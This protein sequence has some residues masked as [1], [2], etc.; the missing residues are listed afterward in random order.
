[1]LFC[2]HISDGIKVGG[3]LNT[4][5][6]VEAWIVERPELYPPQPPS[7]VDGISSTNVEDPRSSESV[8]SRRAKTRSLEP[9]RKGRADFSDLLQKAQ[10]ENQQLILDDDDKN[11]VRPARPESE[12]N[13]PTAI[14]H[15]NDNDQGSKYPER[16]QGPSLP[17]EHDDGLRGARALSRRA[18][19]LVEENAK[20]E[21]MEASLS[22]VTNSSS[23]TFTTPSKSSG[24][25]YE[26]RLSLESPVTSITPTFLL[27]DSF[28]TLEQEILRP[29]QASHQDQPSIDPPR[30][31]ASTVQL[32]PQSSEPSI[33]DQSKP[34]SA[35]ERFRVS[36]DQPSMSSPLSAENSSFRDSQH[37]QNSGPTRPVVQPRTGPGQS[38]STA[39]PEPMNPFYYP[40]GVLPDS[41]GG[42]FTRAECILLIYFAERKMPWSTLDRKMG[43]TTN[44][45]C[46]KYSRKGALKEPCIQKELGYKKYVPF[47]DAQIAKRGT[48]DQ[49]LQALKQHLG[50]DSKFATPVNVKPFVGVKAPIPTPAL[51]TWK[52]TVLNKQPPAAPP[53][54]AQPILHTPL[55]H[56]IHTAIA[57]QPKLVRREFQSQMSFRLGDP[58]SRP[59]SSGG[60]EISWTDESDGRPRLRERRNVKKYTFTRADFG[61]AADSDS[62]P[63]STGILAAEE[64]LPTQPKLEVTSLR[65]VLY[66]TWSANPGHFK[67]YLSFQERQLVYKEFGNNSHGHSAKELRWNGVELHVP[68]S[69]KEV[70]TLRSFVNE[71]TGKSD[72]SAIR[73]KSEAWLRDLAFRARSIPNMSER[74]RQ[75]IEAFLLDTRQNNFK[76]RS[77]L[78]LGLSTDRNA[79]I[80]LQSRLMSREL[81][82]YRRTAISLRDTLRE[83]LQPSVSF[84]GTS[85]DVGTVAWAPDGNRFAAGSVAIVDTHSMQYNRRN[86]LLLGDFEKRS[87]TELP[88]HSRTREKPAE[89]PNSTD[90]M[91]VTQDPHLFETVSMV[92]FSPDG[93]YMYSVGYDKFLRAYNVRE[94]SGLVQEP[95]WACDH[96]SKIDLLTVSSRTPLFATA[97][98]DI[99][100]SLRI[101]CRDDTSGFQRILSLSA[102]RATTNR[103]RHIH[104]SAMKFGLH[105]WDQS[106]LLAGF[107]SST[108]DGTGSDTIGEICL[109]DVSRKTAIQITPA[110][111]NVFDCAWSPGSWHC[112]IAR[113]AISN[114]VSRGTRSEILVFRPDQD[115]YKNLGI[116]FESPALDINDVVFCPYDFNYVAAGATDGRIYVWDQRNPDKILHVLKHGMPCMEI[117]RMISRELADTG[118]RFTNWNHNR[119]LYTGSSD[120]VVK[121]WDILRAPADVHLRDVVSLNSGIMSGA[122]SRDSTKLLL[123]EVNG[124][125]T[126]LEAGLEHRSIKDMDTFDLRQAE[127]ESAKADSAAPVT[128]SE[129]SGVQIAT[130]LR[131]SKQ[132]KFRPM[133]SLPVRQAVQG[134]NY[135]GP[136]DTATDADVLRREAAQFQK[137]MKVQE[138]DEFCNIADCGLPVF[139][140]KEEEGDSGRSRD[141]IPQ[142]IRETIQTQEQTKRAVVPGMLNCTHCGLPARPRAGDKEQETY[143]LCERCGFACLRC[144][145]RVKMNAQI[146]EVACKSCNLRWKVGAL[147]YT[148]IE[149]VTNKMKGVQRMK[150]DSKQKVVD[151]VDEEGDGYDLMEYYHSL[152]E[153]KEPED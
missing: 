111:G 17:S 45:C 121:T 57:P 102:D 105:S 145:Q 86:N 103:Q 116:K 150:E 114:Q 7:K 41:K 87:L 112:A 146:T 28:T 147:G 83:S 10:I 39:R 2:R 126:I 109:Y 51:S 149:P 97:C 66:E 49:L 85:G 152:W 100:A 118:V 128:N 36:S 38:S 74:S 142:A 115:A 81:D 79:S 133:G 67:P 134:R 46:T 76:S 11:G 144:D 65:R 54:S 135:C 23:R 42:P 88:H 131:R 35:I 132:I 107:S 96:G 48:M 60:S 63:R 27:P 136:Y 75:S 72:F 91:H 80:Q 13:R 101:F 47:L 90:A 122:F 9:E 98:Q 119:N 82:S 24:S 70:N 59:T 73:D 140:T 22:A 26:K 37:I 99:D 16:D 31:I 108:P 94:S 29:F 64:E 21:I 44:C 78:Q 120:G 148:L 95:S 69:T 56:P 52:A 30:D 84:T 124:S 6:G 92:D 32:P 25:N 33:R 143:P 138:K 62:E 12:Q 71:C 40:S 19:D 18:I 34:T 43:R 50:G 113:R 141:R 58:P 151:T 5:E 137:R 104:P 1:M 117:D 53:A 61:K 8:L 93:D 15:G 129:Q 123:G 55:T 110:S 139:V 130:A 153:D 77:G 106:Y 68:M 4:P 125:I 89:G 14:E 3:R 127:Q 20:A